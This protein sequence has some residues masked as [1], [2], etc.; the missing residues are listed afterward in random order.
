MAIFSKINI[1]FNNRE[2]AIGILLIALIIFAVTK[3][4]IRKTIPGLIKSFFSKKILITIFLIAIYGSCIVLLLRIINYWNFNLLK[5]TVIWYCIPGFI[6]VVKYITSKGNNNL[7][8]RIIIDNIEFLV[9]FEFVVNFY[10]FPILAEIFII[11]L[12]TFIVLLDVVAQSNRKY[13]SVSKFL[14]V[15]QFLIGLSI[16]IY[17]VYQIIKD[18]NNFG[19]INTL[20]EFLLP[21]ILTITFIPF[22]YFAVLHSKYELLFCRLDFYYKNDRKLR[23]YIKKKIIKYSL[24]NF[25]KINYI[26]SNWRNFRNINDIDIFFNSSN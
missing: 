5:D 25:N 21:I 6:M 14:R 19:N 18:F 7:V 4:S 23:I 22:I 12:I 10:V 3:Q 1:I 24:I 9:I 8:R 15:L 17:S 2:I 16:F 11:P 20:K 13:S 26:N